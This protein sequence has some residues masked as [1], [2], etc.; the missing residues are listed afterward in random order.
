LA[1]DCSKGFGGPAPGS[2]NSSE[3]KQFYYVG[4]VRS[5]KGVLQFHAQRDCP[6][7]CVRGGVREKREKKRIDLSKSKEGS[8]IKEFDIGT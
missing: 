7:G 8:R 5:D 6:P 4:G 1:K 2:R 3:R